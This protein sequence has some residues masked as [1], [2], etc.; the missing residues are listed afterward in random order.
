MNQ[1]RMLLAGPY[2]GP[3]SLFFAT[4]PLRHL[5]PPN[6]SILP[7]RNQIIPILNQVGWERRS[8]NEKNVFSSLFSTPTT[9]VRCSEN[10][11]FLFSERRSQTSSLRLDVGKMPIFLQS[12]RELQSQ[13]SLE[14]RNDRDEQSNRT[15]QQ[16][17]L[18]GLFAPTELEQVS[19]RHQ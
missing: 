3:L 8:L 2:A 9:V 5:A 4:V 15:H 13:R 14:Q 18:Q 7:R 12:Y 16:R 19:M 17:I 11:F 1:L 10:F 6:G